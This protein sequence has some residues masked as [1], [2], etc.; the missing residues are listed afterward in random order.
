[1]PEYVKERVNLFFGLGPCLKAA[2]AKPK[3]KDA[4][5][6]L[7]QGTNLIRGASKSDSQFFLTPK[8]CV[9]IFFQLDP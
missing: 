3:K 6:G 8:L 1:M 9:L 4:V 2:K 7:H 5:T